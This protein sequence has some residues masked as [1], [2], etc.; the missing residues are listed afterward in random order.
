M[1]DSELDNIRMGILDRMERDE[2]LVRYSI[3]GGALLEA[4]L[5]VVAFRLLDF[6]NPLHKILF[7]FFTLSY[8]IVVLGLI[9]LGAHISRTVGRVLVAIEAATP[10]SGAG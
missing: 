3:I 8:T 7:I 10:S 6:G 2:R 9:A 5:F 4:L 1:T